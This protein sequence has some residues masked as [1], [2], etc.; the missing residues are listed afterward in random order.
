[1]TYENAALDYLL[2]EVAFDGKVWHVAA[3]A[4]LALLALGLGV[5]LALAQRGGG[6]GDAKKASKKSR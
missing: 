4:A 2:G 6:A 3:A 1:V 5:A